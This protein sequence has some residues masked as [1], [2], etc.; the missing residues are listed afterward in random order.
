MSLWEKW[1]R[2]KMERMGVKV[3]RK[4]DVDIH[5]TRS[6]PD[7]RKQYLIV[8]FALAACVV[9]VYFL[10]TLHDRYGGH[11]SEFPMIRSITSMWERRVEEGVFNR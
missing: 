3:E 6:K 5:E 1:E 2:E 11:W 9:S 4:S 8:C 7:V 10:W